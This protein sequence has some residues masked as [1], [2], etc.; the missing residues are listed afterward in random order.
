VTDN[1]LP[2]KSREI[3]GDKLGALRTWIVAGVI[4]AAR[5]A[6]AD[7]LAYVPGTGDDPVRALEVFPAIELV[8]V[9][10]VPSAIAIRDAAPDENKLLFDGFEVPSLLLG[11]RSVFLRQLSSVRVEADGFGVEQGRATGGLVEVSS[12][13]AQQLVAELT[14]I[15]LALGRNGIAIRG[16]FFEP[17]MRRELELDP[18]R[19]AVTFQVRVDHRAGDHGWLALS[20]LGAIDNDGGYVRT[21]LTYR[22]RRGPWRALAAGSFM[23]DH[24]DHWLDTRAELRRDLGHALGLHALEVRAGEDTSW[25]VDQ[26][27]YA[28]AWAATTAALTRDVVFIGGL[29]VDAFEHHVTAQPRG[30]LAVHAAEMTWRLAAG[31]YR[32]PAM[33]DAS[34]PQRATQLAFSVE[35]NWGVSRSELTAYYVD[36]ERLIVDGKATGVATNLGLELRE[37]VQRGPWR[38]RLG[39]SYSHA[40][41]ADRPTAP[42]HA[43]DYDLPVH[44]DALA[45]WKHGA[46]QLGARVQLRAGLPYTPVTGGIYDADSDSYTPLYGKPMA[47]RAPWRRELDLRAD[48]W[49]LPSLRAYLDVQLDGGVLGYTY[50]YDYMQRLAVRAPAVL[51]WLGIAG[52]L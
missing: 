33:D 2:E 40:T 4:A 12:Q 18:D 22:Y 19:H 15:D 8:P 26:H 34:T 7:D 25:V 38:A 47:E 45:S 51:P 46:W 20:Q 9:A 21:V 50:S 42:S 48:R 41:R 49:L 5:L 3:S 14:P 35:K 11:G 17:V 36:R 28:G 6:R 31:A 43:A 52:N 32:R 44:V 24:G 10:G 37:V 16:S 29:R 39:V 1:L 27:L 30:M 13:S 23:N